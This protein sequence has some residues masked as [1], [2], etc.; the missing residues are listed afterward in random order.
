MAYVSERLGDRSALHAM[1]ERVAANHTL[2]LPVLWVFAGIGALSLTASALIIAFGRRVSR[3]VMFVLRLGLVTTASACLAMLLAVLG[4]PNTAG[5]AGMMIGMALALG[6]AAVAAVR[7]AAVNV[8]FGLTA[9]AIVA[10]ALT[11]CSLCK[12]A[13]PSSYQLA[14][15]R[16]YG[17]GNEYAAALISMSALMVLSL[18][19]GVRGIAAVIAGVV[20][21]VVLG[22]G[23]LGSNYGAT[24]A[25]VVTFGLIILAIR[26]GGF[27]GRHVAALFVLG[28][29]VGTAFACADWLIAGRLGTHGGQAVGA[30]FGAVLTVAMRKVLMNLRIATSDTAVYALLA[31][32][33]FAALWSWGIRARMEQLLGG[34]ASRAAG[35]RAPA[36][37]AAAAFVLNDSGVVM[38]GIMV[39][40]A[41][42]AL[43]YALL[44]R[45]TNVQDRCA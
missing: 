9:V 14:G 29:A 1:D 45:Q 8:V 17:I 26:R 21:V 15:Y 6:L 38:A 30:G 11:G 22:A 43:T 28:G 2:I 4:P 24:A 18:S 42:V 10:D 41:A 32:V 31:F 35:L 5:Y 27:R 37:G 20:C 25:A 19:A 36:V 3:G 23:N 39:S 44:E 34:D 12:F 33:P 16:Y 40:M 7:R 13:L